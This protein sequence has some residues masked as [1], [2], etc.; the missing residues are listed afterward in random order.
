MK[1]WKTWLPWTLLALSVALNIFFVGGFFW[2]HQH[3]MGWARGPEARMERLADRLDLA[4]PQREELKRLAATMR[5]RGC[6]AFR[7]REPAMR[8]LMD[9]VLADSP[10]RVAI[11]ARLRA[12]GEQRI[13]GMIEML[14]TALPFLGSLTPEQR[15]ELGELMREGKFH[16]FG[17]RGG[18]HRCSD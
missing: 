6:A 7:D 11:E 16:V 13:Q 8:E 2:S 17:R 3:A 14:D 4:P 18:W 15:G 12:M 9:M 10:D 1:S 5:E